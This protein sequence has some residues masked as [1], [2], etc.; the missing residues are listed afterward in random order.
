M[1]QCNF[2]AKEARA[3]RKL[4]LQEVE[5]IRL[6]AYDN[7]RLYKEWTKYLHDKLLHRKQFHIGQKVLL[8]N[9]RL[10]FMP[11]KL[12]SRWIGPFFVLNIF[13]HG[14][15]EIQSMETN[16]IFKVNGHRVKPF[17]ENFESTTMEEIQLVDPIYKET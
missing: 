9:S 13:P 10:K 8:F 1:K 15:I 14:V 12:R 11:G 2:D 7:A 3:E 5:E 17:I 16:K 4:Q 6:E